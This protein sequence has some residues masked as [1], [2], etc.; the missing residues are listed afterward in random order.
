MMTNTIRNTL[1]F[2]VIATILTTLADLFIVKRYDLLGYLA[3]NLF[4]WMMFGSGYIAGDYFAKKRSPYKNQKLR[5][6]TEDE[7]KLPTDWALLQLA[8]GLQ[9][10]QTKGDV[11]DLLQD[12]VELGRR[13]IGGFK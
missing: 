2:V 13:E 6:L 7:A 1:I 3:L 11:A 12:A 8:I 9:T 5:Y 10:C 4:E